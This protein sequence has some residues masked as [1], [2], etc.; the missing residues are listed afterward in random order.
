MTETFRATIALTAVVGAILL[1]SYNPQQYGQAATVTLSSAVA[2]YFG[3]AT[4][5]KED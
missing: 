5:R 1:G 2:G 3:L 4:N